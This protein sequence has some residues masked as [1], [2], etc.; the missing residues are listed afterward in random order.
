[1]YIFEYLWLDI[2]QH[3]RTKIR[4]VEKIQYNNNVNVATEDI[5]IIVAT[6]DFYSKTNKLDELNLLWNYD[7]SSTGQADT[8][9]SEIILKPVNIIKHPFIQHGRDNTFLLLCCCLNTDSSPAIGNTRNI[10]YD[11]FYKYKDLK[12]WFG[13]EQEFFFFNKETKKPVGWSGRQQVQQGE[14]YC[15]VNRCLPIERQ[16]M[17]ELLFISLNVGIPISGINQEVAPAQ[18]E[19]QI[20][21]VEGIQIADYMIF[22]K[23]ILYML[24]EKYGLYSTFHPKPLNGDWN[25]S[26]CHINISSEKT[27]SLNGYEYILD[28]IRNMEQDHSNFIHNYCGKNNDMRLTGKHETSNVDNFTYGIGTR[29]TSVRIP[30]HT[31]NTKCGYFEDRRPGSSIDYYETI[32]QYIKYFT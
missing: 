9:N 7:G 14:Y 15:G 19:Y 2:N 4:V 5:N 16:I 10:A 3:I 18:W 20:G 27:R 31:Y 12:L 26:G 13:L 28:I 21:P 24:C 8:K 32:G 6:N 23:Y 11:T 25:G 22:A 17:N 30:F 29:D 1:M